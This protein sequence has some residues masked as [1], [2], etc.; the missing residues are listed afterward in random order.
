MEDH[1]ILGVHIN[2]RVEHVDAVQHTFTEFGCNIKTRIGLHEAEKFCSPNGLILLEVIGD[3]G[4]RT[5]L[6]TKLKAIEGVDVQ[7]MTFVHD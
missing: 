4:K 5:E 1:T 2:D 3:D 6:E 7:K